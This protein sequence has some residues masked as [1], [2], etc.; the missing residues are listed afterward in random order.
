MAASVP[1]GSMA[2]QIP[3][4]DISPYLADPTSS[5][6]ED[7]VDK[8]HAACCTSGFFQVTGHGIPKSLREGVLNAAK[9]VFGLSHEEKLKLSGVPGRGYEAIGDQVLEPG[10]KPDLKEVCKLQ[11]LLRCLLSRDLGFCWISK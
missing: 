7:V 3:T 9:S 6:A 2:F 11:C 4:V 10:K 8:I 5:A 1:N